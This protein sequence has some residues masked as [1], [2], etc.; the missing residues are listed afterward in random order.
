[1]GMPF[2]L[3]FGV[4]LQANHEERGASCFRS[5]LLALLGLV[6]QGNHERGA[7]FCRNT[8][9]W[10]WFTGKPRGK[11]PLSGPPQSAKFSI[12]GQASGGQL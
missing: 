2:S 8:P 1:M 5:P 11:P 3:F 9:F 6:F 4:G 10:G 7:S 12:D